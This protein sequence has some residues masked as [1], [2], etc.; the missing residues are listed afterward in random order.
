MIRKIT[1][2]AIVTTALLL[3]IPA[4]AQFCWGIKG[5]VNLGNNRLP[6]LST[7]GQVLSL[8]NYAGFFLGPKAEVRIPII[9]LGVEAAA[10]YTQR[11]FAMTSVR[12]FNQSSFLIPLNLKC[13][14]GLGNKA[15]IFVAAGPE[16]EYYV[17]RTPLA[18]YIADKHVL[19]INA[20]LG[21]TL[22]NHVQLGINYNMPWR[23][24]CHFKYGIVQASMAYLF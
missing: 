22:F 18:T 1:C 21:V 15:N 20:G 9:G 6:E 19:N 14:F 3:T 24:T 13:S 10:M 16:F 2:I 17:G 23:E 7:K 8:N 11:N 5:G 12:S 4:Q